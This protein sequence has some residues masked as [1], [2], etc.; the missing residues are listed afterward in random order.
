MARPFAVMKPDGTRVEETY[1]P[2][3][4]PLAVMCPC[5]EPWQRVVRHFTGR[6]L[7][8]LGAG[9]LFLDQIGAAPGVPCFDPSHNHPTGGGAWWAEGYGRLLDPIRRAANAHGAFVTVEGSNEY[10][11]GMVDGYMQVTERKPEDVP[12]WNAVYSGYTTYFGSPQN[13]D[14]DPVS[15]RALQTRELFWGN[16]LGWFL[17]EILD[18]PDK[19]EILRRLCA[20]RQANLDALAYGTL[21]DELRPVEPLPPVQCAWHGRRPNFGLFDKGFALPPALACEMPSVIG[22]WWRTAGG[23]TVL[24]AANLADEERTVEYEVRGCGSRPG[25]TA[26]TT[27]APHELRRIPHGP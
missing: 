11:L 2:V 12:F 3:T 15:F 18:R 10:C 6:I 19:C 8:E 7:D 22:N 16:A 20:F 13:P 25:K 1:H 21:L 27:L 9:S 23:E 26:T 24:L 14:D 4:P 5:C 17:P